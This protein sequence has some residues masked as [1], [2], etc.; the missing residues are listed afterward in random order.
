MMPCLT[1]ESR[2]QVITLFNAGMRLSS[3]K[4]RLEEE[5]ISISIW[6]VTMHLLGSPAVVPVMTNLYPYVFML[7]C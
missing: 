6:Y 4:E 5:G 7:I 1:V 2:G 3:I